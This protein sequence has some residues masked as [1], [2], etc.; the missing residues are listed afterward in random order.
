MRSAPQVSLGHHLPNELDRLLSQARLW[1]TPNP[2]P[3][4]PE[5]SE[6]VPMPPEHGVWLHQKHSLPPGPGH[7]RQCHRQRA[8]VLHEP[9]AFELAANHDEL[10]VQ[11][12]VL[13]QELLARP[14]EVGSQSGQER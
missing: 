6:P 1:A 8:F 9:G 5:E 11:Q 2:R 12:G 4:T 7:R 3:P 13:G 10:L 14:S